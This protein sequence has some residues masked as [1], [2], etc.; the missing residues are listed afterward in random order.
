MKC[1]DCA[2]ELTEHTAQWRADLCPECWDLRGLFMQ[3][4]RDGQIGKPT[5]ELVQRHMIYKD[6]LAGPL[7]RE[8]LG[9]DQPKI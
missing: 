7:M 1:T 8:V 6:G 5:L 9:L 3:G 4:L 2:K